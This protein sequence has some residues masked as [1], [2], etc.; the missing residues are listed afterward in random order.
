MTNPDGNIVLA[1]AYDPYGVNNLNNGTAS[2]NYGFTG[3]YTEP[4]G[5]IYLRAR[6]YSPGVGRFMT[7]DTWDGDIN[8]PLSL[9]RWNY[10]RGNPVNFVDP[11]GLIDQPPTSSCRKNPPGGNALYVESNVHN[12]SKSYWLDTYTAAG[13][14]VQCWATIADGWPHLPML[15]PDGFNDSWGPAQISYTQAETPMGGPLSPDLR[16]YVYSQILDKS[17]IRSDYDCLCGRLPKTMSHLFKLEP[18][19]DPMDWDDAATLMQRRITH[20]ISTCADCKATD[21]YIIAGMAQNG[22]GFLGMD[23]SIKKAIDNKADVVY[24][25]ESFYDDA[26]PENTSDELRR[27]VDAIKGFTERGWVIPPD[28]TKEINRTYIEILID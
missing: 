19:L 1:K 22:P 14:A 21:K 28:I 25:W 11:S 24:D 7:R 15:R 6:H 9:N 3:E 4:T 27:F 8:K 2:T 26:G 16:C 17:F 23:G 20:A 18:T 13:L 10:T 12:L 5:D